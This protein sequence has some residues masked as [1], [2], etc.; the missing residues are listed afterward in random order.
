MFHN[1]Y[2][3][4]R[5]IHITILGKNKKRK[6]HYKVKQSSGVNTFVWGVF[7][8]EKRIKYECDYG[9]Q[10]SGIGESDIAYPYPNL[11]T[12]YKLGKYPKI[13]TRTRSVDF[14]SDSD[15]LE[16]RNFGIGY[17]KCPK[18]DI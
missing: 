15:V 6:T 16:T 12:V 17:L 3:I 1:P 8:G 5:N 7:G 10:S 18:I 2:N 9:W 13:E 14:G 4:L 11:N